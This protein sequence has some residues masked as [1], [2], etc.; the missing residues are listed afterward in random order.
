MST[1]K[2]RATVLKDQAMVRI[3]AV[4]GGVRRQASDLKDHVDGKLD[5]QNFM[6]T[7]YTTA[8]ILFELYRATTSSMLILFVYQECGEKQCTLKQNMMAEQ[9]SFRD[10]YLGGLTL[11]FI[12]L[13]AFL[14]L[15]YVEFNRE[16]RLIEYLE[17][18]D[19]KQF[20]NTAVGETLKNNLAPE[21]LAIIRTI[22]ERYDMCGKFALLMY[23]INCTVSAIVIG[24][25]Y[26]GT[27][28][29]T[30]FLTSVLF[31]IKKLISVYGVIYSEPNVFQSGFQSEALQYN[32]VDPVHMICRTTANSSSSASPVP[33]G[34]ATEVRSP[35]QNEEKSFQDEV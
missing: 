31:I 18:N 24:H 35:I 13:A 27:S 20:D 22:D 15:Y 1:I 8:S 26:A 32:D 17:V 28:T 3:K 21:K 29:L 10:M 7:V 12:T 9:N 16:M 4:P 19:S 2:K 14:L 5:D 11:N 33:E 23:A 25:Y 30:S 34:E 6:Q